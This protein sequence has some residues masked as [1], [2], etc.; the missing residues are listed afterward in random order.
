MDIVSF[1]DP[2]NKETTMGEVKGFPIVV[3]NFKISQ[4][5]VRKGAKVFVIS[6]PG[7]P[8]NVEISCTS[9]GGRKIRIWTRTKNLFNARI[10]NLPP[11][12]QAAVGWSEDGQWYHGRSPETVVEII[13]NP[14]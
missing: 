6:M 8:E 12:M 3:A 9:R 13:N 10:Q 5:W 2:Y 1:F 14:I 4:K 7:D 11:K